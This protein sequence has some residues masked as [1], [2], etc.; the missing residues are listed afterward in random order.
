MHLSLTKTD[1]RPYPL[2]KGSWRWRQSWN[3]LLFVHYPCPVEKLRNLVPKSLTIQEFEGICWIGIIPLKMER[4]M[5][6]P[7]PD[8][9]YISNF[10][11]LNVRVYVEYEGK[12]G[13]YF[14]SLDASN[15]LAVW[16]GKNLFHLP[17]KH[18]DIEF[19][20]EN[21]TNIFHS[22]RKEGED[23]SEFSLSYYPTSDIFEAKP[24]TL[25]Y[26]FTERYCLYTLTPHGVYRGNIHHLPWPHQEAKAK[27][28]SNSI[29]NNFQIPIPSSEPH[30]L[31]SK[32]VDAILWNLEKVGSG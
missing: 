10:L 9:P 7:L 3:D 13:V 20:K 6:R 30:I 11:E 26:F 29:L 19:K 27:I 24:N 15:P 25:E 23:Q 28:F 22:K 4:V 12:P 16:G 18:A 31:Y 14:L 17:Y 5:M 8:I 21:N 32:G 1:H 2:P